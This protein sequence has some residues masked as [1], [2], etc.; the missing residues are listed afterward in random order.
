[1]YQNQTSSTEIGKNCRVKSENYSGVK[2]PHKKMTPRSFSR[3]IFS[4]RSNFHAKT[5]TTKSPK[6]FSRYYYDTG[7]SWQDDIAKKEGTT[8]NK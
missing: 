8:W 6:T 3:E 7:A 5:T 4:L 2:K 1:M